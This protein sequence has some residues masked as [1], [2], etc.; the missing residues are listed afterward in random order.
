MS[1]KII[2]FVI[3]SVLTFGTV[4]FAGTEG[5]RKAD[6]SGVATGTAFDI[7]SA[8]PGEPGLDEVAAA[9]GHNK[10]SINMM[11]VL[12]TGFLVMFMQAGFAMVEVG[13]TRDAWI[14][15]L[16]F[17]TNVRRNRCPGHSGRF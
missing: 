4:S 12:I 2:L 14:L 9:A 6:P 1:R 10:V 17:C 13:L 11:W 15:C 7:P 16:R 5:E 8:K 3:I